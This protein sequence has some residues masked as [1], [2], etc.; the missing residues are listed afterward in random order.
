MSTM[1]SAAQNARPS[2][3]GF[4]PRR[5]TDRPGIGAHSPDPI[6]GVSHGIFGLVSRRA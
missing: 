4:D 2:L 6:L 5:D 3:E 1:A